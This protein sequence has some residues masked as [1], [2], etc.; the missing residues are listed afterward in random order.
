MSNTPKTGIEELSP[1]TA[2]QAIIVN[3][4]GYA[5]IDQLLVPTVVD[6]DLTAAPGSPADGAMYIMASAW[7]GVAGAAAGRLA[8]WRASAGAWKVITPRVGWRMAVLDELDANGVPRI[9]GCSASGATSTW[10]IPESSFS[11][12]MTT[13]GDIIVGGA[14]GVPSR[15]AKGADGKVLTVVSGSV[16]WADPTGG[17]TGTTQAVAISSGTL[18][19]ASVAVDTVLV[20]LNQNITTITL[21]SGAAGV[22]KDLLIRFTQDA[23]GSRTVAGWPSVTW[24]GGNAPTID[25]TASTA[26][27]VVLSNLDNG[28][29]YG[30]VDRG[31]TLDSVG[32]LMLCQTDITG[33]ANGSSNKPGMYLVSTT[34][35][36]VNQCN[37]DA[38]FY[39][40]K[41]SGYTSSNF[42]LYFV[43]GTQV[44]SISTTGTTT[45][46]N[47]SSDR[48]LKT[49]IEPIPNGAELFNSIEWVRYHWKADPAAGWSYGVVAQ[50]LKEV[51]PEAVSGEEGEVD[52]DGNRLYM[53]VDYSKLVPILAA[54]IK[55]Q[56]ERL[57]AL[58]ELIQA[59]TS[60]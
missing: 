25:P 56:D 53:G 44:G 41:A 21:P 58:E 29:W 4:G 3:T 32:R 11:N 23:T 9:Y 8:F 33:M 34:G 1:T 28:G 38:A 26:T 51:Y 31:L 15:L 2:N 5:I 36:Q 40:A 54:K 13:A 43:A 49:D 48:D 14:S 35:A 19:L 42:Q 59:G 55:A 24:E 52:G 17:G 30:F 12:P 6:K 60:S 18:A 16:A 7:A 22:R 39:N 57:A 45:A 20:N 50:Q 37:T 47:T 27:M 10:I 46:F